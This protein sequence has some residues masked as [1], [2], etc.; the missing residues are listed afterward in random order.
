MKGFTP[1]KTEWEPVAQM[2]SAGE[3]DSPESLAKAVVS[4]VAD[5]LLERDWWLRVVDL[6]GM[7]IAYGIAPTQA[8]ATAIELGGGLRSMVLK[9]ASAKGQV[10]R[11]RERGW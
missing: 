11:I 1:R 10:E 7:Q 6:D 2:L 3:Y 8:A 9:V 4:H 5:A